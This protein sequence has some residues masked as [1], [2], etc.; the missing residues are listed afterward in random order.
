M[1]SLE[2]GSG[3][4]PFFSAPPKS[5]LQ[6]EIHWNHA[7]MKPDGT[8]VTGELTDVSG[9]IVDKRVDRATFTAKTGR[10]DRATKTLVLEGDV[11]IVGVKPVA[12]IHCDRV[13]YFS[14]SKRCRASGN[15]SVESEF[16]VVGPLD[17][18]WCSDNFA[19]I[20][21]TEEGLR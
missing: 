10:S 3:S 12:T 16:G 14:E 17:E 13:T 4:A 15:V 19:R 11:V 6:W 9:R 2:A 20:A 1:V 18:V 8:D 5:E 21:T 7:Q